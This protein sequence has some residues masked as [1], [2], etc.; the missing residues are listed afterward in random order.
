MLSSPPRSSR[1][2]WMSASSAGMRSSSS[3]TPMAISMPMHEFSSST[4]PIAAT[5][6]SDLLTRLPSPRP[7]VPSSPVRVAIAES[8]CPMAAA[9]H[10]AAVLPAHF[11]QRMGDLPQRADTYRI[12]QHLE[13]V[14]VV[15]DRLLQ[16]LQRRRGFARMQ[17]ME[18]G[19]A[20]QLRLLLLLG[21]ARQ[22]DVLGHR[23]AVRVAE[24][25]HAD[26]G[27]LAGV[28]L[29]L[30]VHRLFLDL[31]AL[32]AGLHGAQHAAA[33][34]DALEFGKHRLL[35]QLGQLVDDERA[36]VRILVLRQAP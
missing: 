25:V 15:D 9:S 4:S 24:G 35:D 17:P 6:G 33:L 10:A 28:L 34:C 23:L 30:V 5:R 32:V 36:L 7:V 22:L 13:H 21:G 27:Q 19:E 26:D 1:S 14:A 16:P 3:G 8:R 2:C 12:H 18:L 29:H 20:L 11:E 31:A